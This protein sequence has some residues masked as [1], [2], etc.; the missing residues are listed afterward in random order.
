VKNAGKIFR[1]RRSSAGIK[2][3]PVIVFEIMTIQRTQS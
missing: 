2:E 1:K 3:F